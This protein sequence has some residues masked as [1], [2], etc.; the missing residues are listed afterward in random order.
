MV[1]NSIDYSASRF[2]KRWIEN[3]LSVSTLSALIKMRKSN[4]GSRKTFRALIIFVLASLFLP[5]MGQRFEHSTQLQNITH[6][7]FYQVPLLPHI[8]ADLNNYPNNIRIYDTKGEETPFWIKEVPRNT[9]ERRLHTYKINRLDFVDNELIL[10]FENP[11]R[12]AIN[13]VSL[14]IKNADVDVHATLWGSENNSDWY[15]IKDRYHL[16]NLYSENSLTECR[17]IGFPW[18]DYKYFKLVIHDC[19]RYRWY[20]HHKIKIEK[21]GYYSSHIDYEDFWEGQPASIKQIDS[22]DNKSYVTIDFGKNYRLDQLHIEVDGPQYYLRDA[23]LCREK[24]VEKVNKHG[25]RKRK[26][27]TYTKAKTYQPIQHLRLTSADYNQIDMQSA[28]AQKLTLIIDNHDN[29]PLRIKSI[30]PYQQKIYMYTHLNAKDHYDLHWGGA[31]NKTPFYDLVYFKDSL[32]KEVPEITF[33]KTRSLQANTAFTGAHKTKKLNKDFFQSKG[34]IWM[35][36]VGITVVM[37]VLSVGLIKDLNRRK[38]ET[39]ET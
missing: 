27:W 28:R 18:S 19:W 2:T 25:R 15:I 17:M 30:K 24:W 11:E 3:G 39:K 32:P 31:F 26:H 21:V 12:R 10:V 34:W 4:S 13:N 37:A 5:T 6:N 38:D 29:K 1:Y 7:G 14:F 35:A 22:S 8:Y 9:Y 23:K 20:R 16:D 36:L 33:G